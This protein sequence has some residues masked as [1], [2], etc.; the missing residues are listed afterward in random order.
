MSTTITDQTVFLT[1]VRTT[2]ERARART[3]ID[4]IR[5]F[6]EAM[7]QC[8]IWLFEADPQEAPCKSMESMGIQVLPLNV[9]PNVRHY[10]FA[11]KVYASAQ[12]EEFAT[13]KVQTLIWIDP[14]CLVIKPPLLFALGQLSAQRTGS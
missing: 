2:G 4:S 9:P 11:D 13:A 3:L 5:S 7:S 10:Y 14:A 6:G 12:A 8:P 1:L